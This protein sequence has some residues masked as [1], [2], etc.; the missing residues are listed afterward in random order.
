MQLCS[1]IRAK[2]QHAAHIIAFADSQATCQLKRI[3]ECALQPE[4]NIQ[5][6]SSEVVISDS[7]DGGVAAGSL[8]ANDKLWLQQLEAELAELAELTK[9]EL[10]ATTG[11]AKQRAKQL[12]RVLRRHCKVSGS[13]DGVVS[14][15]PR[16]IGGVTRHSVVSAFQ[17]M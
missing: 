2:F 11:A 6:E 15:T 10:S 17:W 16:L 8:G 4:Q 7:D 1:D 9:P 13:G 3:A 5:S 12:A 14:G